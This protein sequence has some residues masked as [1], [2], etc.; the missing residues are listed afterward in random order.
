MDCGPTCLKMIAKLYG[1]DVSLGKLRKFSETTREGVSL[2]TLANAAEKIGFRTLG[3]KLSYHK[4]LDEAIP[5]Y[6]VHWHQN[7]FIVVYKIKK[8]KV[9][10]ADPA[11]GKL[12]YKKQDFIKNWIGANANENLD[13]G[14][15]LL[16]EP[17]PRLK[18]IELGGSK[19]IRGFGFL[20]GY[21]FKY[22]KF[23]IQLAIG[24]LAGSLLQLAFPFLTQSVVD[25]GI[26]NRDINFIYLIMLAQLFLYFGKTGIDIIRSWIL[27]HL[28]ARINI[29]LISDFFIK[30]MNLPIAYFDVKMT[31]DIMQRIMDHSRIERLLTTS[32][33]NVLFSFF[34]II[35]FG[36]VLAW[37]NLTIFLLYLTGSVLYFIWVLL[38]LKRRK[39]LDFKRFSEVSTEQSKV[40]E[41]ISGMQEIKLH[42]AEKQKRWSWE[43]TQVRLFKISIK[44]LTLEQV[45]TVGSKFINEIK[46][47]LLS[48]LSASLVVKG[49]LTLGMML[50]I[51]YI[52]G[53]L[54][55]PINKLIGFVYSLQDAKIALE[56]L[57]EIHNQEDEEDLNPE[58]EEE[59]SSEETIKVEKISFRYKGALKYTFQDI[60]LTIPANKTTAIVGAS[61]SGKTTLLKMLLK[62]YQPEK[63]QI[64]IGETNLNNI[65]QYNWRKK[66][67]VVMQEGF[68]FNDTITNNIC[69]GHDDINKSKLQKAVEI[70]NIKE[71]IEAL[72]LG[73]NTKIGNEGLGMSSGQ[74]QRIL[75][76]R[77]IYK[78][79]EIILFDEATSALDANNESEIMK[80]LND[81]ISNKT[82]V[83]I[84]HRLSTVKDADNIVVLDD[85]KIIEQGIHEELIKLKGYYYNLIKNQLE[86][87]N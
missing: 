12:V 69:V 65:S 67:G 82:A 51:S 42:N 59:F 76:A 72:P 62:F 85:G 35:V 5:P 56:R 74:K 57:S 86:L 52:I 28:S 31:G 16:I 37:Y 18:D 49:E 24:L 48:F 14:I 19:E 8:N 46:N 75:I 68:I 9:Y 44:S 6:I 34:N 53:Q 21:I 33:L 50:S 22:K 20:F 78:D 84:A 26:A 58:T 38:F 29:S 1:K 73:Y 71:Y 30:L 13:E 54:N 36:V 23:L 70:A 11:H 77:A 63:G 39:D 47:I 3:V 45:Q 4:L 80:K 40:I 81:F 60:S 32:S 17:T 2:R 61:G 83:I 25:V 79:P 64:K 27:L 15:A 41:L 43:Y 87:G 10:V 7:H 55:S 66:C